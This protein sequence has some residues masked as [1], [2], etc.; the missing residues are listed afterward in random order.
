MGK[1]TLAGFDQVAKTNNNIN[2]NDNVDVNNETLES[3]LGMKKEKP[4][5]TGI[6]FEP[7]V[8]VALDLISTGK[9]KKGLK[10]KVVN[11]AVKRFLIQGGYMK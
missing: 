6:Y 3:M 2:D 8:L 10:S 7:D 4:I 5:V 1:R 9:G 11:E